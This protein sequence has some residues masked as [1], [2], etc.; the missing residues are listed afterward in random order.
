MRGAV[1]CGKCQVGFSCA[2][3]LLHPAW[4]LHTVVGTLCHRLPSPR[5]VALCHTMQEAQRNHGDHNGW[6]GVRPPAPRV[7]DWDPSV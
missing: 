3:V 6:M 4:Q 7:G 5:R 2:P 1:L